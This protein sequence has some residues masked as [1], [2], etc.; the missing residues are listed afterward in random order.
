MRRPQVPPCPRSKRRRRGCPETARLLAVPEADAQQD[1]HAAR[2]EV[3]AHQHVF[4]VLILL[5]CINSQLTVQPLPPPAP[6]EEDQR[7]QPRNR[8]RGSHQQVHNLFLCWCSC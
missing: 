2:H 3:Q 4:G 6:T 1:R 8:R 5:L 7:Y